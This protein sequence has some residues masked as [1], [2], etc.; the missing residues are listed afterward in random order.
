MSMKIGLIGLSA[1]PYH[2]GHHCLV[3]EASKQN[4]AVI[5]FVSTSDRKRDGECPILGTDMR[6]IW[7]H[8]L[9]DIMPGNVQIEYGGNPIRKVYAKLGEA[10]EA[11]SE[12]IFKVYGDPDDLAKNFP[13]KA[14][15][16]YVSWLHSNG[17]LELHAMS[18][19]DTVDISGT[20]MREFI[21][22]GDKEA[23]CKY[24]PRHIDKDAVWEILHNSYMNNRPEP[25]KF[26]LVF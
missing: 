17:Q 21:V 12:D 24:L 19:S 2:I 3:E 4:D 22:M 8:H 11:Q 10:N 20:K 25:K 16:K 5:V 6:K 13:Q 1:K 18:R 15:D 26:T 23:F 7:V 14:I 9:T